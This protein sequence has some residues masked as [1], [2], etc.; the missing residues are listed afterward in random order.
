M[1]F[2]HVFNRQFVKALQQAGGEVFVVG[3][4]D[5]MNSVFKNKILNE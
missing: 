2:E 3:G 5:L 4:A 1:T